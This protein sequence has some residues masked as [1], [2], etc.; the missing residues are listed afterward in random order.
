MWTYVAVTL[1]QKARHRL[2]TQLNEAAVTMA[3]IIDPKRPYVH[4]SLMGASDACK[5]C[6][7]R[8]GCDVGG[9]LATLSCH[10]LPCLTASV[11]VGFWCFAGLRAVLVHIDTFLLIALGAWEQQ[12]LKVPPLEAHRTWAAYFLCGPAAAV[13]QFF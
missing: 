8:A 2:M 11:L 13:V 6:V 7:Q 12:F 4:M 9:L 3:S 10:R 5:P 1:A